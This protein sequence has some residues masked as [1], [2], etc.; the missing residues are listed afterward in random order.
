MI[1]DPSPQEVFDQLVPQFLIS[2]IFD[3][4]VQSYAAEHYARM[5]AMQSATKNADELLKQLN[6]DLNMA[7]QTQITNEIAEISGSGAAMEGDQ[8]TPSK[9]APP[10]HPAP[11]EKNG[12]SHHRQNQR[13]CPDDPLPRR[14]ALPHPRPAGDGERRPPGGGLPH[15][16][17]ECRCI[18]LEAT[19]GLSCGMKVTNTHSCIQVP[20]GEQ[21]LGRVVDVLGNPIDGGK[22]LEGE[23]WGI[24]RERPGLR[25]PES[26][27]RVL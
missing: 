3:A 23:R 22:P 10:C 8:T 27:D 2:R 16:P 26:Q 20:V 19:Y 12:S 7:R 18:A 6:L 9:E 25:G 15:R 21:V 11:R 13:P 24:Y 4:L 1:Y 5:N 14:G 17:G